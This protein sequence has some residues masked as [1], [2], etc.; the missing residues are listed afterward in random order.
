MYN[1]ISTYRLQFRK[2]FGFKD[3]GNLAAYFDKLGIGTIYASPVLEAVQGSV[4]GYD[5]IN[6]CKINPE[7]GTREELEWLCDELK[8]KHIGWLQDIVPNHMAYDTSNPWLADVLE[9]GRR[10]P[11]SAISTSGGQPMNL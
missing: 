9:K 10:S 3:A 2:Q 1:P 11:F 8:K 5:G 4:H 7:I 6:P